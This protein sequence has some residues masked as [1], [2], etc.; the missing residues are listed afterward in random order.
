MNGTN[1]PKRC[2]HVDY[3]DTLVCAKKVLKPSEWKCHHPQC[4]D[5]DYSLLACLTCG[6]IACATAD[7]EGHARV[8]A[9]TRRMSGS[10]AKAAKK[11]DIDCVC[12][13]K[14]RKGELESF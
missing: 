3:A 8:R 7:F 9:S 1:P 10:T 2:P 4:D 11:S 14:E 5:S 12:A 13:L 6:H